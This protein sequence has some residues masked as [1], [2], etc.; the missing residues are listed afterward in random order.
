MVDLKV[1]CGRLEFKN[2]FVVASASTSRSVEQAKIAEEVGAAGVILKATV[3]K[4]PYEAHPFYYKDS[5]N[6]FLCNPSDPRLLIDEGVELIKACKKETHIPI[7]ANTMGSGSNLDSWADVA[8]TLSAA[9]ADMLEINLGCPNIGLMQR[10]MGNI[11]GNEEQVLGAVCGQSPVISSEIVRAVTSATTIPVMVKMTPTAPN[12]TAVAEACIEAG[13]ACVDISNVLQILPGVD[14]YHDGRPVMPQ[15]ETSPFAGLCGPDAKKFTL[16]NIAQ[17]MMKRPESDVMASGGL[18]NW[19]DCVEALMVGAKVATIC[20]AI[21]WYGWKVFKEMNAGLEKYMNEMGY[22]CIDDFRSHALK[23]IA[24]HETCKV[25]YL[26]PK[27]IDDRC[28]GCGTCARPGHCNA[29][30]MV[31]H[32]PRIDITKCLGCS[33]CAALCPKQALQLVDNPLPVEQIP[34]H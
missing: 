8:R 26:V 1:N 19:K 25:R 15:Y 21:Y 28:I 18:M 3:T 2:P 34:T 32:R 29:I 4:Q 6:R 23:Y 9:G 31:D 13:A 30:E 16:R 14:I 11:S 12:M 5:D 24:T 27:L 10:A 33:L 20:T 22:C 17:L 7:I